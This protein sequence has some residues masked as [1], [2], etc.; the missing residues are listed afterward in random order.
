[1]AKSK[2]PEEYSGDPGDAE[3]TAPIDFEDSPG[4]AEGAGESGDTLAD[5]EETFDRLKTIVSELEKE[6]IKLGEMVKLFEEGVSLIKKC[7]GFLKK[8]RGRVEKYVERDA[9][10]KWVIRG[11]NG[12]GD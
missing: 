5:F 11:L 9:D 6:D 10:G 8:A 7:D 12:S 2:Q 4:S 1:M 3:L